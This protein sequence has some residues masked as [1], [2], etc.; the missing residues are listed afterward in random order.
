MSHASIEENHFL[1]RFP[2]IAL[3]KEVI[4]L[5]GT[6]GAIFSAANEVAVEGFLKQSLPF[7]SIVRIVKKTLASI[8]VSPALNLEAVSAADLE[9]RSVATELIASYAGKE[10]A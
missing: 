8:E 9:A 6:A 2:A 4:K 5:G 7:G 1:E 3:A 10:F